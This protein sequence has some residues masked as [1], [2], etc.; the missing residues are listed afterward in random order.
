MTE[1]DR[2]WLAGL[3]EGEGCFGWYPKSCDMLV[4]V[5]MTD[6]DVIERAAALMGTAFRGPYRQKSHQPIYQTAARG[7]TAVALMRELLPLMGERRQG[8]IRQSLA[9]WQAR[10][11]QRHPAPPPPPP[12]MT[13]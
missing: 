11:N 3:L 5:G 4:Q 1:I 10:P 8:R 2:A 6:R 12:T 7:Q 9:D 13:A